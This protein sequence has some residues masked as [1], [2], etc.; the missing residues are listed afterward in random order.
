MTLLPEKVLADKVVSIHSRR[1]LVPFIGSGMSAGVSV[2][3]TR[4]IE[5]LERRANLTDCPRIGDPV[6]RA[7]LH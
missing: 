1:R 6:Q 5:R 2:S 3:W 7:L 4:L